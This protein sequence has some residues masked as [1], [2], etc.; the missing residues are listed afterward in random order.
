[1][2]KFSKRFMELTNFEKL[3]KKVRR[4]L[5]ESEPSLSKNKELRELLAS[6]E[7]EI[8]S[9]KASLRKYKEEKETLSVKVDGL[10]ERLDSWIESA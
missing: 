2:E 9:L 3:E 6:K 5:E 7:V 8:E 4:L 10:L 1:M